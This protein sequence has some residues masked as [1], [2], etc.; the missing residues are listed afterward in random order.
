MLNGVAFMLKAIT[1]RNH[2]SDIKCPAVVATDVFELLAV[3]GDPESGVAK[4]SLLFTVIFPV[5]FLWVTDVFLVRV[6]AVDLALSC[7]NIVFKIYRVWVVWTDRRLFVLF[8]MFLFVA[9]IGKSDF[10]NQISII[11][12]L[13]SFNQSLMQ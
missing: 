12:W 6:S 1:V 8:P 2:I 13:N 7:L 5:V 10:T 3:K 4:K 9:S 11:V